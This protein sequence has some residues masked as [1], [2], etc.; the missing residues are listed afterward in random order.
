MVPFTT[1]LKVYKSLPSEILMR[2]TPWNIAREE[3]KW[4][5]EPSQLQKEKIKKD[6]GDEV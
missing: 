1:V 4:K 2:K 3:I 5:M 6:D